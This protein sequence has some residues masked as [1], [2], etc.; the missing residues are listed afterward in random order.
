M[1]LRSLPHPLRDE[2]GFTFVELLVVIIIVGLLAAIALPQMLNQTKRAGDTTSK[3][4]AT[5]L[6]LQVETC[7][8][9]ARDFSQCDTE[10][11][12]RD[13]SGTIGATWGSAN[14]QVEVTNATTDTYTVVGHSTTGA[15]F[16]IAMNAD[17]HRDR[18]CL[19]HGHGAC[20]SDGNW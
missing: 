4:D 14:G 15:R 12:I 17:G 1:R 16:V 6:A 20:P 5:N 11:E 7:N 13:S 19:P 2:R 10:T 9:E 8:V 18:N 3:A